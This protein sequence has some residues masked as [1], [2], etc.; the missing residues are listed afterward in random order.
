[1]ITDHTDKR[2]VLLG[3]F[4]YITNEFVDYLASEKLYYI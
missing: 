3:D 1:M 4:A 2:S